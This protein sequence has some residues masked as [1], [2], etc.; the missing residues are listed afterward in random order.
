VEKFAPAGWGG[1]GGVN[2]HHLSLHISTITYKVVVYAPI[3]RA[4]TLRL[5]LLYPYKY[6]VASPTDPLPHTLTAAAVAAGC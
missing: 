6:S 2:N 3:E 4:D 5:F 1:G